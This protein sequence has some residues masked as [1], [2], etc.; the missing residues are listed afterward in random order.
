MSPEQLNNQLKQFLTNVTKELRKLEPENIE[1]L[2]ITD[3]M[4][5]HHRS[6]QLMGSET[7]TLLL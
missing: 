6:M 7:K 1:T 3:F 5:A 2:M 4:D